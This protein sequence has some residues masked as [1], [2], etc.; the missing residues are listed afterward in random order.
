MGEPRAALESYGKAIALLEPIVAADSG[1]NGARSS[2]ARSYL[3]R[4][5]LLLLLGGGLSLRWFRRLL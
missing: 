1:N 5:R 3:R 4:S 2:L